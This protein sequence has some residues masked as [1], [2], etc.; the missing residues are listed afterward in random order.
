MELELKSI[1]MTGVIE[2]NAKAE[3]YRLLNQPKEAESI[4]LDVLAADPE[5]QTALRNLGLAI[6]DQFT[7][8]P[9]DRYAEVEAAFNGLTNKYERLYYTGIL[10]ERRVK[11]QL[12]AGRPPHTLLVT[13]EEA[14]RCFK[15]AGAIRPPANDDS[16]LRWNSCIRLLKEH[17][18]AE[19]HKDTEV[20]DV[21]DSHS[22]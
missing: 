1:S 9:T 12:A 6:T 19:W 5:N 10:H 14:L 11:A 3:H 18:D 22:F 2:A 20:V 21:G 4:C 15:E 17:S 13:L 7:G 8:H 16:I